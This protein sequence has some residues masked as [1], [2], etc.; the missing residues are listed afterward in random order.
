[1]Q[2]SAL[3]W[4]MAVISTN[5]KEMDSYVIWLEISFFYKKRN[6]DKFTSLK[7][8]AGIRMLKF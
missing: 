1:M 4:P 8:K 6:R 3:C 2:E 5:E 7:Q